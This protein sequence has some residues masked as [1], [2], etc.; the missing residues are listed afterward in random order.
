MRVSS[1]VFPEFDCAANRSNYIE[2]ATEH[3]VDVRMR[4]VK[5]MYKPIVYTLTQR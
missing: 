3:N 1:I 4:D 5:I 2:F